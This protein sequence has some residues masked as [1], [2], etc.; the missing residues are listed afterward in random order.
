MIGQRSAIAISLVFGVLIFFVLVPGIEQV[1]FN[2]AY[3]AAAFTS[4]TREFFREAFASVEQGESDQSI[5]PA[6]MGIQEIFVEPRELEAIIIQ[7]YI[8]NWQVHLSKDGKI[9]LLFRGNVD[10]PAWAVE[11]G[12]RELV[13]NTSKKG[14]PRAELYLPQDFRGHL[15]L[16]NE[17]GGF[18]IYELAEV[19]RVK[20]VNYSGENIV[21]AGPA[22]ELEIKSAYGD[23]RFFPERTLPKMAFKFESISGDLTLRLKTH[24]RLL[25]VETLTG[26]L[27]LSHASQHG[28]NYRLEGLGFWVRGSAFSEPRKFVMG[29]KT[30]SWGPAPFSNLHFKTLNG[31]LAVQAKAR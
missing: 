21:G 28:W 14:P 22:D 25:Q 20:I 7:S 17:K 18:R 4:H 30:G 2:G 11:R 6:E 29:T 5:D 9:K 23:T 16:T 31:S 13:I 8:T 12:E 24:I 3:S 15:T 19:A 1:S 27:H 10:P 26:N